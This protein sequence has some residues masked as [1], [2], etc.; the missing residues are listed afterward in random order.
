MENWSTTQI[1]QNN[2][3]VCSKIIVQLQL[4]G[5]LDPPWLPLVGGMWARGDIALGSLRGNSKRCFFCAKTSIF[6]TSVICISLLWPRSVVAWS[7]LVGGVWVDGY[8]PGRSHNCSL[9]GTT[10]PPHINI[11]QRHIS[12]GS[13]R[14]GDHRHLLINISIYLW[15]TS[16]TLQC[17]PESIYAYQHISEVPWLISC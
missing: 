17:Y 8:C 6:R 11:Y 2:L 4:I 9:L 12:G 15:I 5:F 16:P 1:F 7:L 3:S 13:P 10:W 14:S